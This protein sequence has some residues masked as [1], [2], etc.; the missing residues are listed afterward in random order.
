MKDIKGFFASKTIWG[1]FLSIASIMPSLAAVVG[2]QITPEDSAGTVT[3][4][5]AIGVA[6]GNLIAIYGRVVAS[7]RIA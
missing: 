1:A 4:L 3:A 7:K 5:Q 6:A 2:Y